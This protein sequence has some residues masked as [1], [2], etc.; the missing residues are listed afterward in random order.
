MPR[1]ILI[2]HKRDFNTN[3]LI[4]EH[5]RIK[6][7][8]VKWKRFSLKKTNYIFSFLPFHCEWVEILSH[9][10]NSLQAWSVGT[11]GLCDIPKM[12]HCVV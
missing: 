4:K 7:I 2:I 12:V 1:T 10:G 5:F 11:N 3:K 6:G 8:S 9:A